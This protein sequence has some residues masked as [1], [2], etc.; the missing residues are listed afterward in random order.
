MEEKL[1]IDVTRLAPE[2]ETIEGE[3]ACVNL[4]ESL[5]KS[6]G[7][8]RYRLTAQAIGSELLVRGHLE[9][10]FDLVCS[11][12]GRDFDDTIE[13]DD[14]T[15][16]CPIDEKDPEVDLTGDVRE[17]I[18]LNLSAYPVCSEN[19]PGVERKAE[20]PADERWGALD[21]LKVGA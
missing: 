6:F 9:Q 16:S 14:Y 1:T 17:S 15:F 10:D 21:G 19:C 11:R 7:G 5:V 2:G 12:C 3:V 13:V 4:D 18:I 8:L 20:M